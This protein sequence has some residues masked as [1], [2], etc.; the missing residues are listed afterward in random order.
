MFILLKNLKMK[1]KNLK[2]ASWKWLI[3]Y[4][5]ILW[6]WI[7][8][9][10]NFTFFSNYVK[11]YS[12]YLKLDQLKLS[13]NVFFFSGFNIN[14][15]IWKFDKINLLVLQKD[16]SQA[17]K[18]FSNFKTFDYKTFFNIAN[19]Y[20]LK[21]Y[22]QVASNTWNY[23]ENI[24]NAV[25]YYQASLSTSPSY[26]W[27]KK[28]VYNYDLAKWF[29]Q[30]AYVNFCDNLFVKM[31]LETNKV[32]STLN[33]ILQVLKQQDKALNNRYAYK[34]LKKCI[35]SFKADAS[36]NITLI[37][38]N[39]DFFQKVKNGLIYKMEDY[40]GN[41]DLC[42]QKRQLISDK[43]WKSLSGS[44][45]YFQKFLKLQSDLLKV[46]ERADYQQMK[47]LC[48]NK[49]KVANNLSKLNKQMQK[50]FQ[51]LSDLAN[52]PKPHRK[53]KKSQQ[54]QAENQNW[55]KKEQLKQDKNWQ[56]QQAGKQNQQA[57]QWKQDKKGSQMEK[58]FENYT[59]DVIKRLEKQNKT[60]IE[61]LIKEK[62]V[63]VYNP[64]DYIK[65]LF[66]DFYW[67]D[68]YY[69]ELKEQSMGK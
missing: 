51:N 23:I 46:Y 44:L 48:N 53:K 26:V 42:Y 17:V 61:K 33:Q 36:K 39:K 20:L 40:V 56:K 52:K 60:Y 11:N 2:I 62:S 18:E 29:L 64:S 27:K 38:E 63:P 9:A 55:K 32:L 19:I 16:F 10:K 57:K 15:D 14:A 68:S 47:L 6:L 1:I 65:N 5:F 35:D 58:K 7:V 24:Q 59:K 45:E 21:S 12:T 13:K 4:W 69:Q 3:L 50:N 31:I 41:E 8:F 25:S 49:S 37:Y 30:F 67:N 22:F 43:Y 34:D 54:E 28:I 66:K